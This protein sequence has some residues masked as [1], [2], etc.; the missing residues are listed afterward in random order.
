MDEAPGEDEHVARV[1]GGVEQLICN[2]A[3]SELDE[4]NEHLARVQSG[5]KRL[6]LRKRRMRK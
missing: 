5:V 1:E 3:I 6:V 4:K 2:A